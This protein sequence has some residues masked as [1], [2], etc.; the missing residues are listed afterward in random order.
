[1][2]KNEIILIKEYYAGI[3]DELCIRSSLF[4]SFLQDR[5]MWALEDFLDAEEDILDDYGVEIF[6]G[7][8][9][10]VMVSHDVDYVLKFGFGDDHLSDY[11]LMNWTGEEMCRREVEIYQTAHEEGFSDYLCEAISLGMYTLPDGGGLYMIAMPK[12]EPVRDGNLSR[13][14]LSKIGSVVNEDED[15]TEEEYSSYYTNTEEEERAQEM[16]EQFYGCEKVKELYEFFDEQSVSDIHDGNIGSY[17][18]K[19]VIFDY[20]GV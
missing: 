16:L 4:R 5:T 11:F 10:V 1:M 18:H 9:R 2:D 6:Y 15:L 19:L 14:L 7:A 20:A 8:C 13:S 12:A 3:L 17:H